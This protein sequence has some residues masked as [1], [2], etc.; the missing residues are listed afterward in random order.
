MNTGTLWGWPGQGL[1]RELAHDDGIFGDQMRQEGEE[2]IREDVGGHIR[3]SGINCKG[4]PLEE[5]LEQQGER[6]D[7]IF[8]KKII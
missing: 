3:S 7:F 1:G 4:H 8:L 6:F 2:Q 5:D